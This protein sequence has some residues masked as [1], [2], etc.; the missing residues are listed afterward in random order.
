MESVDTECENL[1]FLV[2]IINIANEY[3]GILELS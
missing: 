3:L 1:V 2:V